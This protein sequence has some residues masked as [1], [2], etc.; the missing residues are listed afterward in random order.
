MELMIALSNLD[1][2]RML[3]YSF[4][5]DNKTKIVGSCSNGIEA[6]D[7]CK[8][9][10]PDVLVTDM[11]L[12]GLNGITLLEEVKKCTVKTKIILIT[13]IKTDSIVNQ[14][15]LAGADY[16]IMKPYDV[17][18][19]KKRIQDMNCFSMINDSLPST[20]ASDTYVERKITAILNS[21]GIMPN[22]KGYHYIKS[23]IMIS[24][25]Q[26][27]MQGG[28]TKMVYPEIARLN[29]TTSARVERA[30]RHAIEASWKRCG[31][32]EYYQKLG[33]VSFDRE[34]RPTNSEFIFTILE[35]L[36]ANI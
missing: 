2:R 8:E 12:D 6:L 36:K 5:F 28:I 13:S 7:I 18:T 17:T 14:A 3:E 32:N 15:L 35:Y 11:L 31:K 10:D 34:K 9:K 26:D 22:L 24:Y 33:F 4:H 30:I 25:K 27:D 21:T 23:A 19:L 1:E 16:I 29:H 20:V